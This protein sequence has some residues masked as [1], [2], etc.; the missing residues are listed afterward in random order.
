M[1]TIG[2]L[3]PLLRLLTWILMY[4]MNAFLERLTIIIIVSGYTCA[5]KSSTEN[6]DRREWL[7]SS[8]CDNSRRSSLKKSVMGIRDLIIVWD[9]IVVFWFYT[10]NVHTG[11]S[12]HVPGYKSSPKIMSVHICTGHRCLPVRHWI[13]VVFLTPFLCVMRV[14]DTLLD[15]YIQPL[16]C[17]SFR[18]VSVESD[19][20]FL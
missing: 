10:H 15:R 3:M 9:F 5:R 20:A 19:V 12:F 2:S 14:G 7:T 16:L 8:L 6:P 13:I 11:V 1:S 18:C 17:V 4:L